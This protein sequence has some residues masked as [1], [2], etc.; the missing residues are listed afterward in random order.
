MQPEAPREALARV[1]ERVQHALE[2]LGVRGGGDGGATHAL[3]VR[4]R[5]V[6]RVRRRRGALRALRRGVG[7]RA[8][9]LAAVLRGVGE[10]AAL[11]GAAVAGAALRM[12]RRRVGASA[13]GAKHVRSHTPRRA[14]GRMQVGAWYDE[15]LSGEGQ[16][17]GR[18]RC[19]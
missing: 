4:L 1:K 14:R 3:E 19:E 13:C 18:T 2:L 5:H 17:V 7:A 15:A 9:A 12:R 11:E 6:R 8:A 10:E 16:S